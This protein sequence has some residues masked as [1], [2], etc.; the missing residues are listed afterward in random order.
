[1]ERRKWRGIS[2]YAQLQAIGSRWY[3]SE[4]SLI[5]KVPSAVIPQEYNYVIN[6][7]HK[8]FRKKVKLVDSEVYFWDKRIFEK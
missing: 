3:Q 5:L 6:T 2:A 8:D 7:R 4:S 1:M